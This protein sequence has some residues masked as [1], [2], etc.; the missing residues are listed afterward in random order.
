MGDHKEKEHYNFLKPT[1]LKELGQLL[2]AGK[3]IMIQEYGREFADKLISRCIR[4]LR[5]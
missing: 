3:G 5:R 4:N 2:N 1:F